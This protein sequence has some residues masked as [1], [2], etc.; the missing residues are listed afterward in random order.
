[1]E[2]IS[3][4]TKDAGENLKARTT[5]NS[6]DLDN[7]FN[8]I[9]N[10]YNDLNDK[11]DNILNPDGTVKSYSIP[12][13]A[14]D[15]KD[16][17]LKPVNR[18]GYDDDAEYRYGDMVIHR[19]RA[20]IYMSDEAGNSR[21]GN[22][23][24]WVRYHIDLSTANISGKSALLKPRFKKISGTSYRGFFDRTLFD[25]KIFL[26]SPTLLIIT[27]KCSA[28]VGN[29]DNK[30]DLRMSVVIN[31]KPIGGVFSVGTNNYQ[32]INAAICLWKTLKNNM[33]WVT[34]TMKGELFLRLKEAIMWTANK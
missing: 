15:S 22:K 24:V 29:Y 8:N 3:N 13:N 1:M 11:L 32:F 17:G 27:V 9:L 7:E 6:E 14:I 31:G 10:K 19:D 23:K 20:Y 18:G 26:R 21:I 12:L 5:V 28:R 4:F 2:R 16:F 25:K 34:I 30:D 33:L